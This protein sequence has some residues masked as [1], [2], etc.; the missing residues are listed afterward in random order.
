MGFWLCEEGLTLRTHS[1]ARPTTLLLVPD[2]A[3]LETWWYAHHF[4]RIHCD[5]S[6][7]IHW[8]AL[9]GRQPRQL[10]WCLASVSDAQIVLCANCGPCLFYWR[11]GRLLF[12]CRSDCVNAVV[13]LKFI[14][15][16]FITVFFQG[17]E[18]EFWLPL[19]KNKFSRET[20]ETA[21]SG[22][23]KVF[24]SKSKRSDSETAHRYRISFHCVQWKTITHSEWGGVSRLPSHCRY[25]WLKH[26]TLVTGNKL[27]PKLTRHIANNHCNV[28]L[29]FFLSLR[30]TGCRIRKVVVEWS[31]FPWNVWEKRVD[32]HL[33]WEK[34]SPWS[35]LVPNKMS[36]SFDMPSILFCTSH[37]RRLVETGECLGLLTKFLHGKVFKKCWVHAHLNSLLLT[38]SCHF[39]CL[40]TIPLCACFPFV[41]RKD[42]TNFKFLGRFFLSGIFFQC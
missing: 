1:A 2:V 17:L 16:K 26:M 10:P 9:P 19:G 29:S 39:P 20:Q 27:S 24:C 21:F 28:F 41:F 25:A 13:V 37:L 4:Q 7:A 8:E 36:W 32:R 35:F 34:T 11:W 38:M 12:C 6:N 15:L 40:Q 5:I 3:A 33:L 42:Q 31:A 23:H 30:G 18:A 22:D 14:L